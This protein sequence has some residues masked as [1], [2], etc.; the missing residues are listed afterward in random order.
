MTSK[1][2]KKHKHKPDEKGGAVSEETPVEA[3]DAA[4]PAASRALSEE[5]IL[6]DRLLRLQADFDNFRKRTLREK[7][8]LYR[9]ANEDLMLELLPVLDHMELALASAQKS[10]ADES[11]VAGV[12][13]VA[14]QLVTALKKFGLELVDAEEGTAFDPAMQEAIA[15][16]PSPDVPE[17]QVIQQTR[18]G[19]QLAGRILR[20][21]QVVVSSGASASAETDS[22]A[23]E[24]SQ[25]ETQ[26]G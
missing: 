22:A 11:F 15:H 17:D 7:S 23:D 4:E 8:D 5:E 26:P 16:I 1:H 10:D 14:D 9:M 12:R 25:A 20:A 19:Y 6:R 24:A 18:R 3:D 21:C 2:K 13:L